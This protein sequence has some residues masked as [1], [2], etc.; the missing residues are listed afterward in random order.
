M[1]TIDFDQIY[2]DAIP[3]GAKEPTKLFQRAYNGAI[4]ATR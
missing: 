2:A 1:S 4:I 3:A